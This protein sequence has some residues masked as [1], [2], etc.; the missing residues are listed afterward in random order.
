MSMVVDNC[1]CPFPAV[2]GG[3]IVDI[4]ELEVLIIE[5]LNYSLLSERRLP[6]S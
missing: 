2:Q 4:V 5:M 6:I 3:R 1:H